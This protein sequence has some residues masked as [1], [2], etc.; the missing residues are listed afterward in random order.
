MAQYDFEDVGFSDEFGD[1]EGYYEDI[2][3]PN[4]G[5]DHFEGGSIV[6]SGN[7]AA[8]LGLEGETIGGSERSAPKAKTGP[9]QV[10]SRKTMNEG[11]DRGGRESGGGEVEG[12]G[13]YIK[14]TKM[15]RRGI[16]GSTAQGSP[17]SGRRKREPS[18]SS[19]RRQQQQQQ[20]HDRK[21]MKV[22]QE[23]IKVNSSFDE[24]FGV[25]IA[26]DPGHVVTTVNT[27]AASMAR[28]RS[29]NN[30]N[31]NILNVSGGAAVQNSSLGEDDDYE[32]KFLDPTPINS[33]RG[34]AF[35]AVSRSKLCLTKQLLLLIFNSSLYK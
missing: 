34:K 13:R 4:G 5:I 29:K 21:Q 6:V 16:G 9:A 10:V 18:S 7:A 8:L 35:V 25:G 30:E 32:I 19:P 26:A 14:G 3:V 24:Y 31:N 33:P 12:E 22:V 11:G 15:A 1:E 17:A 28:N 20:Q 23:T 2:N 27:S